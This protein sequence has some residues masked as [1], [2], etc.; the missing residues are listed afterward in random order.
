MDDIQGEIDYWNS[1]I[2]CYVLGANPPS[3][4]M[5]GFVRRIWRN[6]GLDKVAMVEKRAFRC[7]VY[8][9]GGER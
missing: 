5:E 2:I 3:M 6:L 4:V 7:E 8:N 1:A 9:N